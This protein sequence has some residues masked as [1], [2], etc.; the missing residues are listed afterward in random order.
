MAD[1]SSIPDI[2]DSR[3][4]IERIAELEGIEILDRD[5]DEQE[6]LDALYELQDE[7][8]GNCAD[9][10]YGE[11]FINEDYFEAYAEQLADDLGLI[12]SRAG[13]PNAHINWEDAANALRQDY[14]AYTFRGETYLAR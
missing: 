10:P 6:E 3:E 11:T 13:W 2:F 14:T 7:A 12:D 4:V 9:W 8:E 1:F 5:E